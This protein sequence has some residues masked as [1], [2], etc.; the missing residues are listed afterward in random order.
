MS[1]PQ[2]SYGLVLLTADRSAAA[3]LDRVMAAYTV[4]RAT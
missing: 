1:S 2:R 3:E 4:A